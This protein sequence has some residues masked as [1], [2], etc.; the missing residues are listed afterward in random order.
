MSDRIII[1]KKILAGKPIIRGTRISVEFILELLA[2]GMTI[3]EILKNY[4]ELKREDV[5]AALAYASRV[6]RNEEL[7]AVAQLA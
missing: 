4:P 7:Y 1:D 6:L 3:A 5:L 2:S